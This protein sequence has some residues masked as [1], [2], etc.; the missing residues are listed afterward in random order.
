MSLVNRLTDRIVERTSRNIGESVL[1]SPGIDSPM[2]DSYR[3]LERDQVVYRRASTL[4]KRW[5]WAAGA[6]AVVLLATLV[7]ALFTYQVPAGGAASGNTLA[8]FRLY[9]DSVIHMVVRDGL[10]WAGGLIVALACVAVW[11]V[12]GEV[13][14]NLHQQAST[15][16]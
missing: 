15:Q 6:L 5:S 14:L 4:V 2:R 3:T 11:D 9:M 13:R 7:S 10:L 1:S 8:E 12:L 16:A